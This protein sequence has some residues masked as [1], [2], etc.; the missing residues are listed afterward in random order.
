[1]DAKFHALQ[2]VYTPNNPVK[3]LYFTC[4]KPETQGLIT[5]AREKKKNTGLKHSHLG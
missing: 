2:L 1:M 3:Y 4:E 5:R